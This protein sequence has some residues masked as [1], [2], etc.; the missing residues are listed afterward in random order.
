MP[1]PRPLLVLDLDETLWHGQLGEAAQ[2]TF[3]LRPHLGFFL[4]AVAQAYDL[5]VWTAASGDWLQAGLQ[6][7]KRETGVDL[8]AQAVFLWNR[9][10]CTWRRGED[11]VLHLRKPARKFRARWLRAR[12]P[13]ERILAVD[14]LAANYACGYGHL[15]R[16]TPW[17]G[18][19][20]DTELLDL[21]RYLLQIAPVPDLRALEKRGWRARR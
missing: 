9:D 1:L 10:R 2:V 17:T 20:D 8:A 4:R 5:A 7:L 6:A 3:A 12:Y 19:P 13:R 15:V 16:V 11:G 21:A 18:A 14:D